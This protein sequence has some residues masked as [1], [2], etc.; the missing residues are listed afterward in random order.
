MADVPIIQDFYRVARERDFSRYNQLRILNIDAG[1]GFNVSFD[2]DDLVYIQTPTM[3]T[4]NIQ[5]DQ[6]SFMGLDFNIP[7]NV[8][9]SGSGDYSF[10]LF[11]DQKFQLWSKFQQ[12]SREIF[13]DQSSTGNYFAPKIGSSITTVLVDNELKAVK[14]IKLVGVFINNVGDI[15][16]DIKTAGTIVSFPVSISYQYW[17]ES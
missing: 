11:A 2:E 16:Y 6:A 14:K 9:Y 1:P 5:S 4:R 15:S 13:D 10:E 17:E 8:K 7:G 12:W 3:P